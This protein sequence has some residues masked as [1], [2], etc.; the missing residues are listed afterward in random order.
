MNIAMI[1]LE[2][3]TTIYKASIKAFDAFDPDA[4]IVAL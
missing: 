3:L 2:P 4:S 1:F